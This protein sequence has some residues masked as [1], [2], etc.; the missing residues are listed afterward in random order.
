MRSAAQQHAAAFTWEEVSDVLL[1]N[2]K[3]V[4]QAE[5]VLPPRN[6]NG[7]H[8]GRQV[9]DAVHIQWFSRSVAEAEI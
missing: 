4:G 7:H 8:P 6:G 3:F 5:G 1:D 9:K 2:V